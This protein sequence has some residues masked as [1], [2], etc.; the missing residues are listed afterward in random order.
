MEDILNVEQQA[1]V[2]R[3]KDIALHGY[4][5]VYQSRGHAERVRATIRNLLTII[6]DLEKETMTE[7]QIKHMRDRFLGWRLPKPWNPDAGISYTP[8]HPA[9]D[10]PYGTNLFDAG[11]AEAMVRYMVEGLPTDTKPQT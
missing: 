5:I 4:N 1:I 11:Q 10:P 6:N 3:A 9:V 8:T 7:E 2:E